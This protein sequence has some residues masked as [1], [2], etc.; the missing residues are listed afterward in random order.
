ML[1][2]EE[3]NDIQAFLKQHK[4]LCDK[5]NAVTSLLTAMEDSRPAAVFHC[6]K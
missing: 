4:T 3:L 1:T 2:Q 6:G 5:L